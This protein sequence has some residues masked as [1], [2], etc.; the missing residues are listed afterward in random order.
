MK[1]KPNAARVVT[2]NFHLLRGLNTA[3]KNRGL[4][5]KGIVPRGAFLMRYAEAIEDRRLRL[6][7][8][9]DKAYHQYVEDQAAELMVI[10]WEKNQAMPLLYQWH[11]MLDDLFAEVAA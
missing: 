5:P 10:F 9:S 3:L 2:V 11:S 7:H 1:G 4:N 8:V 6:G